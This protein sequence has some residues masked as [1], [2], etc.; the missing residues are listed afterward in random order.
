[1]KRNRAGTQML[2]FKHPRYLEFWNMSYEQISVNEPMNDCNRALEQLRS[3]TSP[4]VLAHE[5][6]LSF[7]GCR[8]AS[9][10]DVLLDEI[11]N[12]P[13]EF[14][15]SLK[16]QEVTTFRGGDFPS[17]R[18]P[19]CNCIGDRE[20]VR[21][22]ECADQSHCGIVISSSLKMSGGRNG[23]ARTITRCVN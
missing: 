17:P 2:A 19:R 18:N 22:V 12:E 13:I 11:Q 16:V 8:Y 7:V 9:V 6:D 23:I 20:H 14:V 15:W 5:R 4:A 21:I 1:M 10:F 3:N